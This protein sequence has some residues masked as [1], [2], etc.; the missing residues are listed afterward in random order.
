MDGATSFVSNIGKVVKDGAISAAATVSAV[1]SPI[2]SSDTGANEVPVSEEIK[3]ETNTVGGGRR[4]K[5][6]K[7][8]KSKK[9]KKNRS[10]KSRR[11][12]KY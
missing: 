3:G 9:N 1:L 12:K 6:K 7:S 11:A 2:F 10:R 4:K 8:K 5:S